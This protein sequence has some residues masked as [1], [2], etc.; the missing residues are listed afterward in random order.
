M[1][2]QV[3]EVIYFRNRELNSTAEKTSETGLFIGVRGIIFYIYAKD[4]PGKYRIDVKIADQWFELAEGTAKQ[5]SLEIVDFD[6]FAP[7]MR[8]RFEAKTLPCNLTV[9]AYGYPAVYSRCR[10][11]TDC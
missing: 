5:D 7:E 2:T 4:N 10:N 9:V 8:I 3:N 11:E 1:A 6:F